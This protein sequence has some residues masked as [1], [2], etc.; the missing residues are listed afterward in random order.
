MDGASRGLSCVGGSSIEIRYQF[1]VLA[2]NQSF[3]P[4]R[5]SGVIPCSTSRGAFHHLFFIPA[6]NKINNKVY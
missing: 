6:T 2:F 4:P 5:P 3:R 1:E